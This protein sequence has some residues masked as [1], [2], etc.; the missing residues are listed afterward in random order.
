MKTGTETTIRTTKEVT[1]GDSVMIEL[2]GTTTVFLFGSDT[3]VYN[4]LRSA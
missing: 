4:R 3:P 1:P 2:R